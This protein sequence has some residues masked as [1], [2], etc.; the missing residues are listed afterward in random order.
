M[1]SQ[2]LRCLEFL[3]QFPNHCTMS[4]DCSKSYIQ[5]TECVRTDTGASLFRL[6][7]LKKIITQPCISGIPQ[8]LHEECEV[9]HHPPIHCA[10]NYSLTKRQTLN[11]VWATFS[12]RFS[13]KRDGEKK[14]K[15]QSYFS[16]SQKPELL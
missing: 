12:F 11:K 7:F 9:H 2:W 10:V 3:C 13:F 6:P 15:Q 8:S 14:T 5:D 4:D 1:V 16:S